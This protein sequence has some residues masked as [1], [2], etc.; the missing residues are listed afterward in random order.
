[1]SNN[2]EKDNLTNTLKSLTK[3]TEGKSVEVEDIISALKHRGFGPLL[4]APALLIVLPTGAIP[5]LPAVCGFMILM[6]SIQ[7][8]IGKEHPW[9]PSKFK[10]ISFSKQ[11]LQ[12]TSQAI[13]PYTQ[14]ID[15][16]VENRL[17][18]FVESAVSKRFVAFI[19]IILST[20]IIIIG[21]V[22][23][24]PAILAFPILFLAR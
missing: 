2:S 13:K 6:I 8:L 21:F 5:G 17:A 24:M 7:I 3:E 1:M 14:K 18:V 12:K 16:Y 9:L 20:A 11:K 15:K 10:K 23:M 4:M 19:S 22:P